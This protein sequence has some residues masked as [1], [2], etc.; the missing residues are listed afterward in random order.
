[1]SAP[2]LSELSIPDTSPPNGPV[3]LT[4]EEDAFAVAVVEFGGNYRGA[5]Q[6]IFGHDTR[7]PL[8]SALKLL[9]RPEV[10]S[11]IRTLAFAVQD[12]NL[13]SK[14]EHMFQM[15]QIRD[16]ALEQNNPKVAYTAERSRGEVMGWYNK[17]AEAPQD[18]ALNIL[19]NVGGQTVSIEQ[20]KATLVQ[21]VESIEMVEQDAN[22]NDH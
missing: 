22:W 10:S 13:L 7:S 5:Y 1:M 14:A 16:V 2:A 17:A 11:R 20:H 4:P 19:I 3:P 6:S 15:A 21:R 9:A 8:A 12:H 18:T